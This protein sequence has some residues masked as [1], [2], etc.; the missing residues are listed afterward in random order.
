MHAKIIDKLRKAGLKVTH[1]KA[2]LN[3]YQVFPYTFEQTHP[4]SQVLGIFLST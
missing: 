1:Q 3:F 4:R 2:I